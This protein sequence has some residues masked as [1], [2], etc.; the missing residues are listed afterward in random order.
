[1]KTQNPTDM[2]LILRVLKETD[3]LTK[4]QHRTLEGQVLAGDVDGAKKGLRRIIRR[5]K[6]NSNIEA[7][8][9]ALADKVVGQK[10]EKKRRADGYEAK[11]TIIDELHGQEGEK[12]EKC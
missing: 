9:G 1:M 10:E 3:V 7:L 2:R 12:T 8:R 11:V 6:N 4:Q 5:L